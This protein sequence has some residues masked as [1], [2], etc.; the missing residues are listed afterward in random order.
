MEDLDVEKLKRCRDRVL[1]LDAQLSDLR[2]KRD[3]SERELTAARR[4]ISSVGRE[5]EAAEAEIVLVVS[6][7]VRS[8]SS[9]GYAQP[10]DEG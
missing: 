5:L 4:G 8:S 6:G 3:R 1:S 10:K 7:R 9:D 2:A